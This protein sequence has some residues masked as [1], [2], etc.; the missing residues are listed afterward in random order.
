[1]TLNTVKQEKIAFS[2]VTNMAKAF[3]ID[4]D[5]EIE[6]S[7]GLVAQDQNGTRPRNQNDRENEPKR[8]MSGVRCY[9]CNRRGHIMRDCRV[10]N[11]QRPGED[12][13]GFMAF[14][15]KPVVQQWCLD[16]GASRHM[17]GIKELVEDF[18]E[19]KEDVGI[20][21]GNGTILP[22]VGKGQM[23]LRDDEETVKIEVSVVKG[24]THNLFSIAKFVQDTNGQVLFTKNGCQLSTGDKKI[25]LQGYLRGG[26]YVLQSSG[27]EK[28]LIATQGKV[29]DIN[30]LHECHGH[31]N[32]NTLKRMV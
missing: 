14:D 17:T 18:Q 12:E 3:L 30:K 29:V 19:S 16:S 31:V 23:S 20:T 13:F 32:H 26:V 7:N 6:S 2:Q 5:V 21:I 1:L 11:A 8:N 24:L 4:H 15:S 27:K 28:A 9:N 22:I 10:R 25:Q